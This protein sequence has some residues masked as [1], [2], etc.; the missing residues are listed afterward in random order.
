MYLLCNAVVLFYY[1]RPLWLKER[2]M[3]RIVLLIIVVGYFNPLHA[4][5]KIKHRAFADIALY[6]QH[7][8]PATALSLNDTVV[9]SQLVAVVTQVKARVSQHVKKGELLAELDCSDYYLN[10]DLASAQL[11]GAQAVNNRAKSELRRIKELFNKQLV[12]QQNLDITES[13]AKSARAAVKQQQVALKRAKVDVKRCKIAAPFS[14]IVTARSVAV[15]Q[16]ASVGMPLF[17]IVD[18][19]ELEL[20]ASIAVSDSDYFPAVK[21]FFFDYGKKIPVALYNAGGVVDSLTRNIE[22]RFIFSEKNKPLPGSAGRLLWS[23][24]RPFMPA[25]YIVERNGER[26]V[27]IF[28]DNEKV[29]RFRELEESAPG[30]PVATQLPLTTQVVIDGLGILKDGDRL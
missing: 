22:M 29:V 1:S 10:R 4:E 24:P 26:G 23:D 5:S 9:S 27:F 7:S 14:G 28:D 8:A 19:D 2:F 13:E 18:S 25:R 12:S 16:L 3:W 21:S 6:P 30:R 20:S 11:E 17:S 15:G